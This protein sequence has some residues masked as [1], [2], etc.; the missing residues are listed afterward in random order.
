MHW[1]LEVFA[2]GWT[3]CKKRDWEN[4]RYLADEAQ[5]ELDFNSQFSRNVETTQLLKTEYQLHVS[6]DSRVHLWARCQQSTAEGNQYHIPLSLS[7][8]NISVDCLWLQHS[9]ASAFDTYCR[10]PAINKLVSILTTVKTS[11]AL[12]C[13]Q[14]IVNRWDWLWSPANIKGA[15][16]DGKIYVGR[17]ATLHNL[18]FCPHTLCM[19]YVTNTF[20]LVSSSVQS[21]QLLCFVHR[22]LN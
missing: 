20:L 12:K 21:K 8:R 4:L 18:L 1:R 17:S 3:R 14:I 9:F 2:R 16:K 7:R 15:N 22:Q 19:N 13:S 11:T 5:I 10:P 6:S